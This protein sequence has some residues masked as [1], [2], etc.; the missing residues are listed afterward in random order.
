[1]KILLLGATSRVALA[2]DRYVTQHNIGVELCAIDPE[3]RF[4]DIKHQLSHDIND[5]RS[6]MDA[7]VYLSAMTDVDKCEKQPIDAYAVNADALLPIIRACN[8]KQIKLVY[9]STDFVF[10]GKKDIGDY[11]DETDIPFPINEYGKS[12]NL[13]ECL[14]R[15]FSDD[16]LILRT[17]WLFG[18]R[19][20]PSFFDVLMGKLKHQNTFNF[21]ERFACP[22]HVDDLS[23]MM[24]DIIGIELPYKRHEI[25]HLAGAT[26]VALKDWLDYAAS[27]IHPTVQYQFNCS[28]SNGL[29]GNAVRPTN[30]ALSIQ[31]YITTTG[32]T[33]RDWREA[34]DN[35]LASYGV[36]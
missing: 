13:G 22:T 15:Q 25:Y 24:L 8:K 1:M 3:P 11:Y 33:P 35:Y 12:K 14:I 20:K 28:E 7:I 17:S 27:V 21:P 10:S 2:L 26:G 23:R 5:L 32:Y 4:P 18:L 36:W 16:S 19:D 29:N 30:S 34:T 9:V 6:D 31:K